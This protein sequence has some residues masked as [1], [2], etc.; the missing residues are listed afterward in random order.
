MKKTLVSKQNYIPSLLPVLLIGGPL[1]LGQD[2]LQHR[3]VQGS[4]DA[5]SPSVKEVLSEILVIFGNIGIIIIGD[6]VALD[7][8]MLVI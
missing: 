1:V 6:I 5:E 4:L 7:F 3:A 8:A 2:S